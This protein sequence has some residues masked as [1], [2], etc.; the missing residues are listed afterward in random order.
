M[1]FF[2]AQPTPLQPGTRA[3]GF[4][5]L[6]NRRCARLGTHY[7]ARPNARA[8]GPRPSGPWRLLPL[9][10]PCT[11][12]SG[13]QGG[14]APSAPVGAF[15]PP[16]GRKAIPKVLLMIVHSRPASKREATREAT[17]APGRAGWVPDRVPD[18]K[19]PNL[20][21]LLFCSSCSDKARP[22]EHAGPRRPMAPY[23]GPRPARPAPDHQRNLANRPWPVCLPLPPEGRLDHQ[24]NPINYSY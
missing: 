13:P 20:L 5:N 8:P 9:G 12:K 11:A 22:L 24:R 15:G 4:F 21:E 10:R 14:V 2:P 23:S 18:A 3:T 1:R 17:V 6:D 7:F 16:R 19:G